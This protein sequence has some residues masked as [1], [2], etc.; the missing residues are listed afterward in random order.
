MA[1]V[2]VATGAMELVAVAFEVLGAAVLVVGLLV[3]AAVSG[4]VRWRTGS[5]RAAY[6]TLRETFGGVL[7]LGLEILVAA[8][9]VRT[10]A[11][12]PTLQNV[13]VLGLIV[14]I[15]TFLS[16]SLQI[17]IDGVPPW[18]RAL[19]GGGA[20]QVAG[21]LARADAAGGS[22]RAGGARADG[23]GETSGGAER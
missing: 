13:S 1:A 10:V 5:G 23:P 3:A 4:R 18:R 8:D 20:R 2:T 12:E 22:P 19:P 15:R 21:A 6:R 7:L 16:F 14:L 9:L 17:E 11:V